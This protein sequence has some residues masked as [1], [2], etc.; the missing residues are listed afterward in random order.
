M[1]ATP[2]QKGRAAA[3][4]RASG[5]GASALP[6]FRTSDEFMAL[7]EADRAKVSA[8]YERGVPPDDI[9][10]LTAA[11]RRQWERVKRRGRPRKGLGSKPVSVTIEADLLRRADAYAE[12]HG[13]TRAALVARGLEAV[14]RQAG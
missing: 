2:K 14:L 11:Q 10:P 13:L 9:R 1:A 5:G 3:T 6:V 7:S 4:R 12:Q 8:Y